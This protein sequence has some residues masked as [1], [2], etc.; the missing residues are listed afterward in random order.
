M[1]LK[2]VL[3]GFLAF[4]PS[5]GYTLHKLF[6]E[7]LRPMLP[8]IYR[9]LNEMYSEGLVEFDRVQQQT[10]PARNVFRLTETGRGELEN[11]VRGP[12]EVPPIREAMV[13]RV[14]FGSAVSQEELITNLDVYIDKKKQE[15]EYYNTTARETARKGAKKGYGSPLDWLYWRL[16]IDYIRRRG[17]TEIEWAEDVIREV[18]KFDVSGFK[19]GDAKEK[20][21]SKRTKTKRVSA[22][23]KQ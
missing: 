11:W 20:A 18:S 17:N 16:C 2:H 19:T 12:S 22:K 15:I 13:Q 9:A 7:P 10:L 23:E 1:P 8:Q 14:W 5:S 6:F 21:K 3:L 4:K